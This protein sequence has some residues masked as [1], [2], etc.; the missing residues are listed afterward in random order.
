M[1]QQVFAE[2]LGISTATLSSIYND[3]TRPTL[4]IVEAIHRKL[5][6]INL[7]W[8]MFGSGR[9]FGDAGPEAV[10]PTTPDRAATQEPPVA[11][12][13]GDG[14][15]LPF[16]GAE[17]VPAVRRDTQAGEQRPKTQPQPSERP[18]RHVTEIRVY[19]DDQTWESF[20]PSKSR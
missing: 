8:L 15:T 9:M 18:Q 3:R 4:S 11:D 20:S 12:L 1:S 13:F 10:A 14:A 7:D 5:P 2:F 6:S 16:A 19:Y 17:P